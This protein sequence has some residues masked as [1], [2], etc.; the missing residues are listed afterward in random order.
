MRKTVVSLLIIAMVS[1]TAACFGGFELSRSIWGWNKTV[2]GNKVV[3]WLVFLGLTIIPVYEIGVLIDVFIL[4]SLEFWTGSN[5]MAQKGEPVNRTVVLE[6][7]TILNYTRSS[8]DQ[9]TVEVIS[10]TG[11]RELR[12]QVE[13]DGMRLLDSTGDVIAETRET[14]DG[15]VVVTM[16]TQT[17]FFSREEVDQLQKQLS[18]GD[19]TVVATEYVRDYQIRTGLAQR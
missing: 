18:G 17:T 10:A 12:F 2:S 15:A 9:M 14:S 4:N 6:D 19:A 11:V 3:Q 5:P 13:S 16:N 1:Q 7:G 8:Q